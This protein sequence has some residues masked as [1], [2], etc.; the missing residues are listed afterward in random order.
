MKICFVISD[1]NKEVVG[2]S[3]VLLK[4]AHE[5]GHTALVMDVG[6]FNFV[7]GSSVDIRCKSVPKNIAYDSPEEFLEQMQGEDIPWKVVSSN[8]LDVLF[9]RNNP[10]EES[11]SRHWAEH[12]GL[13]FAR[14]I[15][16]QG[17]LVL[18]D[19]NAMAHS[20]V[21]KMYFEELPQNIKPK[22]VVTRNKDVILDFWKNSNKEIVLKP[23]EGSGGQSIYLIG[24]QKHNFN[25]IVNSLIAKGYVIAQ[26][27]LPEVSKGDVRVILMNGKILTKEGQPAL[28]R[29]INRDEDEFR[30]NLALGASAEKAEMTPEIERIVQLT[31]PKLIRDG[32]FFVGLDVVKDK[33]IEINC[34]SP[35]GLSYTEE[36]GLP[37]FTDVVIKAI[38]RK[39]EY[40]KVHKDGISNRELATLD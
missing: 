11:E 34:M 28:I 13:A 24:K 26:E 22:S 31:G 39:V 40:R 37:D 20:F 6:G 23:L 33:L 14:M 18:N 7:H 25:Q 36:I 10:T 21:D 9:V 15:Q 2:T 38:E 4:K 29:R 32:F 5:L 27:F 1:L 19:A 12:S 3:V 8:E 30:S 17:V 35:G 16:Q